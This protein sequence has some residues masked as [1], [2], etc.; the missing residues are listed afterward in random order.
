MPP[1]AN[2]L[3]RSRKPRRSMSPCTYAS[4]RISSSSSKSAAVFRSTSRSSV[5]L[6]R[7]PWRRPVT[8]GSASRPAHSPARRRATGGTSGARSDARPGRCRPARQRPPPPPRGAG[9]QASASGEGA[10][11][12][13][14]AVE[15]TRMK[16]AD[17]PPVSRISA[18]LAKISRGLRKMPPPVP[19]RPESRPMPRRRGWRAAATAADAR[20]A[21]DRPPP[22]RPDAAAVTAATSSTNPPASC[23]SARQAASR[24]RRRRAGWIP[25]QRATA[26]RTRSARRA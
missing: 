7:P 22:R 26:A 12:S 6:L 2:L 10:F 8:R 19:V 4:N 23:A 17:T 25:A 20:H 24:L 5:C 15:F 9:R 13:S 1:T 3:A 11:P 14:P 18:Q 16:A 21:P